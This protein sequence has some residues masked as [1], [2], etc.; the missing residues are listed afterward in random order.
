MMFEVHA[1]Q[2]ILKHGQSIS[3][4]KESREGVLG[5][6]KYFVIGKSVVW[7]A[8]SILRITLP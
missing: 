6:R 1:G 3:T 8:V 4:G 7:I 2:L 5:V